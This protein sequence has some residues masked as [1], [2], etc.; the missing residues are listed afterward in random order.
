MTQRGV[1]IGISRPRLNRKRAW[2]HWHPTLDG[3]TLVL[4]RRDSGNYQ[5]N[6]DDLHTEEASRIRVAEVVAA[7]NAWADQ[8]VVDDLCRALRELKGHHVRVD[9]I[10]A[11]ARLR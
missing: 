11:R 8:R 1:P 6:L 4:D 5:V 3:K 10:D 9:D 7:K 2:G